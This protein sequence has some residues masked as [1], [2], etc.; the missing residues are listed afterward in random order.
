MGRP[1]LLREE[2]KSSMS[3]TLS[4]EATK[5]LNE[6]AKTIERPK[7]YIIEKAVVEYIDKN[8]NEYMNKTTENKE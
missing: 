6:M 3:F 5:R 1:R 8:F 7:S 4:V 2:R